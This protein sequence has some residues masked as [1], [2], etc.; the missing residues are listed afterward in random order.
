VSF[1]RSNEECSLGYTFFCSSVS[2]VVF[3]VGYY[4][5]VFIV[6]KI[7]ELFVYFN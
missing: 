4:C 1:R 2:T 5:E 3:P 6:C 7:G